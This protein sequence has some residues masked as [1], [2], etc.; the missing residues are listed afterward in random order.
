MKNYWIGV[1]L[2]II[3]GALIMG[4]IIYRTSPG[5][6]LKEKECRYGFDE[7]VAELE[8]SI[9]EHGWTIPAI[10]DLQASLKKFGHDVRKVKVFEICNPDHAV[11]I[12][13][14]NEERIVSAMM[15]CRIAVYEKEDGKIF[16]SYMNS[17]LMAG[18]MGGTVDEVMTEATKELMEILEAIVEE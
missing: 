10:H 2:G 18:A 11:K 8:S 9:R 17:S 16:A 12:L 6:M 3:S 14:G 5:M 7:S 1:L 13:K 15:P 4:I